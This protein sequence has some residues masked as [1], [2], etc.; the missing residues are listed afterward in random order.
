ML[1][2]NIKFESP[3]QQTASK[4]EQEAEENKILRK[5]IECESESRLIRDAKRLF[6]ERHGQLFCEICKF[7]FEKLYGVLGE[8]VIEGHSIQPILLT[9]IGINPRVEDIIMVCANCHRVIHQNMNLELDDIR[10][11]I[12]KN[13]KKYF[14]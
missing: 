4:G 10:K 8:A 11:L 3:L 14:L 13:R 7:G 2:I 9:R 5:H 6:I 1:G 12:R